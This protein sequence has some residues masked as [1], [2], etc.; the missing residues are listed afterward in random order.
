MTLAK[1]SLSS[2]SPSGSR[3]M[4]LCE[5]GTLERS[6]CASAS[7]RAFAPLAFASATSTTISGDRLSFRPAASA[8]TR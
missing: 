2:G 1:S 8:R 3:Q 5:G 4:I 7:E 6:A